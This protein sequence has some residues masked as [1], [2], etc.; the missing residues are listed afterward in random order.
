MGFL[1][2]FVIIEVRGDTTTYDIGQLTKQVIGVRDGRASGWCY[3]GATTQDVFDRSRAV[4]IGI[5][6]FCFLV[7]AVCDDIILILSLVRVRGAV[8]G[9]GDGNGATQ[10]V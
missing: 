3:D 5:G 1:P 4:A 6:Y 2:S 8:I 7:D 10:Y 9:G